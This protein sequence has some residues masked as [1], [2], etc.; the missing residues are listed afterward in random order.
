[1]FAVPAIVLGH[2]GRKTDK[3]TESKAKT[4]VVALGLDYFE[5]VVGGALIYIY[6]SIPHGLG[7]YKWIA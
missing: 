5:A 3:A 2:I 4:V 6:F 7:I 1:L